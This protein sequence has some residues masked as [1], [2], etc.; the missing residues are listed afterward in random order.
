VFSTVN[1]RAEVRQRSQAIGYL[2][3]ALDA[4]AAV[5]VID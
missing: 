5:V 4:H 3:G 1:A 2:F